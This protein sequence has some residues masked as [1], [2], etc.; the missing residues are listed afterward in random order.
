MRWAILSV[1]LLAFILIPFVL[2]EGQFNALS[3]RVAR[4]DASTWYTA[5]AIAALLASDVFL[6]IP[7]SLVSAAAGVLLGFWWGTAMIWIGMTGACLIGYAFGA[8]ASNA[9]RRF[10][11]DDSLKRARALASRYGDL[12][13]VMCRPVP[14]LAEASVIAAG[15][16]R[17]PLRRFVLLTTASNFGIAAVYAAIGAMSMQVGSFLLAFLAALAAPGVALLVSRLWFRGSHR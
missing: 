2:F 17:T 16:V 12:G 11:G 15:L 4:G 6:P 1:A 3:D 9:A 8:R 7:S 10:V 13:L 5:A 14:V